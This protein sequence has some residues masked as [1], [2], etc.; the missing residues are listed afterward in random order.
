MRAWL[1]L[2]LLG[3]LAWLLLKDDS[4]AAEG[5]LGFMDSSPN[6]LPDYTSNG[7]APSTSG[8]SFFKNPLGAIADAITGTEGKPGDLNYRNNNPGNLKYAGQPGATKGA[9]N[10]AVFSSYKAG[11]Q[12]LQNQISLD[13]RRNPEWSLLQ[14]MTKYLGGNPNAPAVSSEGNPFTKANSIAQA[15]GVDV[16]TTLGQLLGG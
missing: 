15:L 7:T 6:D 10:F 8:T 12:A 5:I 13:A 9:D 11:Y 16:N 3:V 1:L 14:Y 4:S 2:A